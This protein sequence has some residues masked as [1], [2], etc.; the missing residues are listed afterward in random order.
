MVTEDDLNLG[1]RHVMQYTDDVEDIHI[2]SNS[3]FI[4]YK[5]E[6]LTVDKKFWNTTI[7]YLSGRASPKI[8]TNSTCVFE[9]DEMERTQSHLSNIPVIYNLNLT[10]NT[11]K[12]NQTAGH[13]IKKTACTLQIYQY[14]E[15]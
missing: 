7:T 12:Q 3:S 13:S 4:N 9:S 15:R 10:G 5:G 14:D 6:K 1:G 11:I 8:R 2:L